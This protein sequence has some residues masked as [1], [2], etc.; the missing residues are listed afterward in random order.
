MLNCTVLSNIKWPTTTM[1]AKNKRN[2]N[3]ERTVGKKHSDDV[4]MTSQ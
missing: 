1:I 3:A 2:T 4:I